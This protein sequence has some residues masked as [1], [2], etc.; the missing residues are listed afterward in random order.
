MMQAT[1]SMAARVLAILKHPRTRGLTVAALLVAATVFLARTAEPHYPIRQWLFWIYAR[2]WLWCLLFTAACAST[3]LA[4]TGWLTPAAPSRERAVLAMALGLLTFFLG[5]FVVGV[6]GLYGTVFFFAWPLSMIVA[7]APAVLGFARR[8]RRLARVRPW[9][10]PSAVACVVALFGIAA[11]GM[12]YVSILT[13]DNA[14][15]DARFYHLGIA[16]Q[17][18][19]EGAI[20]PTR[21]AWMPAALPQ[22][23][24]LVYT[25]AFLAPG[26]GPFERIA[27]AA[28]TEMTVFLWTLAAIP[29]LV[30][31][32]VPGVRA[33]LAW[34]AVFL[35]PGIF[36]YDS[37]LTI[38]SDHVAAFWAVPI[39]LALRRAWRALE[40]RACVLLAACMA[41]AMLT[42]Y[43]SMMLCAFPAA[44]FALRVVV[45]AVRR[46]RGRALGAR[47]FIGPALAVTAGVLL[48]APHWLKNWIFYGDPIFPYLHNQ[49]GA[50]RWSREAHELWDNWFTQHVA[51]W[52]PRGTFVEKLLETGRALFTFPFEPHDW[53]KFHGK[54]PVFGSLFTLL[55]PI[56]PFVRP[57]ARVWAL[58][59]AAYVAVGIWYWTMHVD[60][61]L[62]VALPWMAAAVAAALV[63]AWR[64]HFTAR[65]GVIALVAMHVIWGGDVYFIPGHA[66]IRQAPVQ[67]VVE[68][69][70]QGHK[71]NYD[72]RLEV[73]DGLFLVGQHL[74]ADAVV[75]LHE[76]NPRLGL[77]CPVVSDYAPWQ[78]ALRYGGMETAQAMHLELRRIGITHI[79]WRKGVSRNGDSLAGDLRF[80]EYVTQWAAPP[81]PVG[82][83][84]VSPL[85]P[86]PPEGPFGDLVAYL[87]CGKIYRRGLHRLGDMRVLGLAPPR[88]YRNLPALH[89]APSAAE[90][91]EELLR[92]AHYAVTQSGCVP[93]PPASALGAFEKVATRQKEELWV[94]RRR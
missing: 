42:K 89:P 45:L 93:A 9:R 76:W 53:P 3:G 36:L 12:V 50:E 90:D 59:L 33:G 4:L 20:L 30:R 21:E 81:M 57:R 78:W 87:G 38:A 71:G 35:F 6:L 19:A 67:R 10:R 73:S 55:L 77:F 34:V 41:G 27:V 80:F 37:S 65:V 18:V 39:F 91:L 44:A 47:F 62:Q 32:L 1:P 72:K 66:M 86:A 70:A 83:W 46:L 28:H 69:L 7:G 74:P 68:L 40:P 49:L 85:A 43:Q 84:Q 11:L 82:G 5:A 56:L 17:Y 25:W 51:G 61:Y 54:R 14:A 52:Q 64:L 75:L 24:S 8:W 26:A 92:Q 31:W 13:P 79:L 2:A 22:L 88:H 16:Q 58:F 29:V 15:F 63:L 94:R 48:T 60:R 23:A